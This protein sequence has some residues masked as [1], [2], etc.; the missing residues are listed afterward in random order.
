MKRSLLIV[1]ILL[2]FSLAGCVGVYYTALLVLKRSQPSQ[3]WPGYH[4]ALF[5]QPDFYTGLINADNQPVA[6]E[7]VFGGIV[8][9][10]FFVEKEIARFFLP[11]RKQQPKVVVIIGPN[12]FNAG[13]NAM[14]TTQYPY[15]TPWGNLEPD[16]ELSN[17][18]AASG[19]ITVEERPFEK[20]HSI[21]ALVSFVKYTFPDTKLIPIILKKNV[22]QARLDE[23]VTQLD[24]LL[25]KD[26]LVI[27]S[28]DFSHHSN[29]V[30]ADFHD[31]KS[32]A[33]IQS[34]D[35]ESLARL[36]I[37]SPSSIYAT[38]RFLEKRGAQK[39]SYFKHLN[40]ATFA[41]NLSS[42]DVTSYLFAHFIKGKSTTNGA[43]SVLHFGDMIFNG[44]VGEMI[45]NKQDP[46]QKIAGVEGNFLRGMDA[47]VANLEGP[48]AVREQCFSSRPVNFA[49]SPLVPSL[50]ARNRIGF[51]NLAN[52]H[53]LDCG[54]NGVIETQELLTKSHIQFFG[55]E[56]LG[57]ENYLVK[58]VAD[59]SLVL[60]GIN[61]FGMLPEK[62]QLFLGLIKN[63][64]QRYD[65]V[66]VNVHWGVEYNTQPSQ[67][68][69]DLAHALVDA[70]AD[71][72]IGHHPHVIQPLEIYKEKVI[73]YSLGNFV[74]SQNIPATKN[75]LA[76]G[77][78]F[79]DA[80]KKFYLFPFENS[81]GSPKLLLYQKTK[82]FCDHFLKSVTTTE[83]CSFGL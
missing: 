18:L 65:Y 25:P 55:N 41:N 83:M 74:S 5:K 16:L 23:L 11:L 79:N 37:D 24:I 77:F 39:T 69:K 68:Q 81:N 46:F 31:E 28:V 78:I 49:F 26:S 3:T 10:H 21:S 27:A 47:V 82:Q 4:Y 73:F 71:V 67:E 2:Y 52:N 51:V 43:V 8:S 54:E 38:L 29:R 14:L 35:F 9:H 33:T 60:L 20:E 42:E 1:A 48:I 62:A 72:I 66:A 64:K 32:L 13:H 22:S 56:E 76:A 15:I 17:K 34:F 80:V 6:E 44:V 45:K 7:K 53:R 12:H 58:K 70:G 59:K 63:L 57:A 50:L 75:G 30:V 40:S 36:E 61:T 19:L